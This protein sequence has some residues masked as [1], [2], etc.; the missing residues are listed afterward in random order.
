MPGTESSLQT[1]TPSHTMTKQQLKQ[2]LAIASSDRAIQYIYRKFLIHHPEILKDLN[3]NIKNLSIAD[4]SYEEWCAAFP[5][6]S[7]EQSQKVCEWF[8][9]NRTQIIIEAW[10]N[11]RSPDDS[12]NQYWKNVFISEVTDRCQKII[13]DPNYSF[14]IRHPAGQLFDDNPDLSFVLTPNTFFAVLHTFKAKL[15]QA[16]KLY[17]IKPENK[18]QVLLSIGQELNQDAAHV[19]FERFIRSGVISQLLD[20]IKEFNSENYVCNLQKLCGHQANIQAVETT[21]SVSALEN[22]FSKMVIVDNTFA[23]YLSLYALESKNLS[24]QCAFYLLDGNHNSRYSW[25]LRNQFAEKAC[26]NFREALFDPEYHRINLPPDFPKEFYSIFNQSLINNNL[27]KKNGDLIETL[28]P[29]RSFLKKISLYSHSPSHNNI[30]NVLRSPST[31][32]HS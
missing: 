20:K 8:K 16:I 32:S 28:L 14:D 17:G 18:A 26:L 9:K 21:Q 10:Y 11:S 29:V 6:R 19:L 23:G 5:E 2:N 15:I 7:K 31:C 4:N 13:N 22:L 25:G 12:Y 30:D 24:V 1:I 27:V 3:I